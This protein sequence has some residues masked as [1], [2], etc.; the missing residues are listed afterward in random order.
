MTDR[1]LSQKAAAGAPA[2]VL[3]EGTLLA[4]F[5][6]IYLRD[7]AHPALPEGYDDAAIARRLMAGPYAVI[8]HTARNMP[9]PLRVEWHNARPEP[10][11]SAGQHVVEAGF[12]S[13]SGTLVLAG[14]TDYEPT[15]PRLAVPAGPLGVRAVLSGL[16]TLSADGL[17]GRDVYLLQ[18]WPGAMPPGVQVLKAWPGG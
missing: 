12:A 6:Q 10:D 11:L 3:F 14:L 13:P 17:E 2:K 16:D 7:A 5:F 4:D 1:A 18:L 9:V 15:A 8:L